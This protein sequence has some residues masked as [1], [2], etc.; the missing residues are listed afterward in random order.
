MPKR[1]DIIYVAGLID[2]DGCITTCPKWN[3]RVTLTNT[4][5]EIFIWLKKTFKGNVNNQ[6]LP[7]NPK[8]SPAWKWIIACRKDVLNFLEMIYPYLKI[9]KSQAKVVIVHLKKYPAL[10]KRDKFNGKRN[11]EKEAKDY[12]IAKEGV[13]KLKT[14]KHY[15]RGGD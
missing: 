1:E 3:F 15:N 11:R 6:H 12:F 13:R 2:A 8:H 5:K 4:D 10:K 9:K 14:D 7:K